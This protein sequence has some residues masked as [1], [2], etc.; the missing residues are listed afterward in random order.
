MNDFISKLSPLQVLLIEI[1]ELH[2]ELKKTGFSTGDVNMIVG[3]M[4]YDI[5]LDRPNDSPEFDEIDEYTEQSDINDEGDIEDYDN[6]D[7]RPL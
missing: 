7:E 1:H 4:L 3:H 2:G 5:M 6:G